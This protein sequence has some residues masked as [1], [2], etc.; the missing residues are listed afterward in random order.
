MPVN[1][2]R[3]NRWRR[4][5]RGHAVTI[6]I[7]VVLAGAVV[8]ALVEVRSDDSSQDD[9]AAATGIDAPVGGKPLPSSSPTSAGADR[10]VELEQY[11][12]ATGHCYTWEQDLA[13]SYVKDVPC[14]DRHLFEAVDRAD[15]SG[16]YSGSAFFPRPEEWSDIA[17]R[18]CSE[19]IGEYLGYPLDP[20]GRFG[21]AV[22]HPEQ[23]GWEEGD[24]SITCGIGSSAS[25]TDPSPVAFPPFEGAVRGADQTRVR[26][27]GTCF[28]DDADHMI[29]TPCGAPH[30][31][32]SIG[33]VTVPGTPPG[34][35]PPSDSWLDE[36]VGP[37]C[38]ELA[39]PYLRTER[40]ES[41]LLTPQWN[42]IEPESWRAG[43]RR[44]N[45]YVGFVDGNGTPVPVHAAL[46]VPAA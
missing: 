39:A 23:L 45:C 34:G 42:T 11:I 1:R 30:N 12:Y 24:R 18:Y 21:P 14:A 15:L 40:F 27:V 5:W 26:A 4:G 8:Y 9:S 35:G 28:S 10:N 46:P 25:E 44:T 29:E 19:M 20:Y 7:N 43:T 3:A 22:I 37:R 6:A 31:L 17:G 41:A 38:A 2:E 13:R 36:Q 32:Q 16:E 33:A